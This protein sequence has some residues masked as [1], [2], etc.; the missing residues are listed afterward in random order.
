MMVLEKIRHLTCISQI[1]MMK[2][3]MERIKFVMQGSTVVYCIV[4]YHSFEYFM[5][6][7]F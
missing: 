1:H 5:I 2:V 3:F 4:L 7:K 6:L